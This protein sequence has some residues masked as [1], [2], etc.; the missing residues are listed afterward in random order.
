[1]EAEPLLGSLFPIADNLLDFRKINVSLVTN[2]NYTM[3]VIKFI[4]LFLL[5]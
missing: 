1:M 2:N 5:F 3:K 4:P